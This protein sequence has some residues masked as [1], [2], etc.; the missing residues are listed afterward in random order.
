MRM[1]AANKKWNTTTGNKRF[2][3]KIET[4]NKSEKLFK[5]ANSATK[6]FIRCF[7]RIK[8]KQ[9]EKITKKK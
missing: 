7:Q 6:A 5:Y 1:R 4:M 9:N 8:T 3:C 2:V